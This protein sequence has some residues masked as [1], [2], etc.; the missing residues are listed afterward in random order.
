MKFRRTFCILLSCFKL[1]CLRLWSGWWL[2]L[3]LSL[4]HLFCRAFF[5]TPGPG[6]HCVAL[7][8][9]RK[10]FMAQTQWTGQQQTTHKKMATHN[11]HTSDTHNTKDTGPG[12][13]NNLCSVDQQSPASSWQ[14]IKK[15]W[16]K[17]THNGQLKQTVEPTQ[18]GVYEFS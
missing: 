7:K 10:R 17:H 13:I 3:P 12:H 5:S 15:K 9:K 4:G 14:L 6:G 8:H 2:L 18:V 1:Y 11:T 16:K